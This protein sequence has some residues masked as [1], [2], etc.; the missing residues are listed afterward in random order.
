MTRWR[1]LGLV[2]I[3]GAGCAGPGG[4]EGSPDATV[5]ADDSPMADAD[6]D[7]AAAVVPLPG[8]GTIRGE[9]GVLS[10]EL[11]ASPTA[12]WFQGELDF[13]DDRYDDPAERPLLTDGGQEMLLDG[14]AGGSSVYSEVFAF[15][16]LARCEGASLLKTEN[17]IAYD[18]AGNPGRD[19]RHQDRRERDP[20]GDLSLRQSL[21]ARGR[22]QLDRAE[23][24]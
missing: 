16:W 11:L 9:C 3:A 10:S 17:E 18:V 22:D 2:L 7:G 4:G 23:A 24:R 13:A 14:N 12:T 6:V 1:G 15:E 20:A 19:R 8:F 5:V 21:P